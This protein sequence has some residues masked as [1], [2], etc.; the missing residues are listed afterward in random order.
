MDGPCGQGTGSLNWEPT[1]SNIQRKGMWHQ[2]K[3]GYVREGEWSR[4]WNEKVP[5][6]N[7][8]NKNKI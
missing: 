6:K 1:R 4:G 8:N 2:E 5:V 3:D 7:I